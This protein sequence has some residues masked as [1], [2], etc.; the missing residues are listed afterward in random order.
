MTEWWFNTRTGEVEEGPQSLWMDR[1]G[2][3]ES[4]ADAARAN[5]IIAERAKQWAKEDDD[6]F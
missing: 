1:L 5:E 2:P 6:D 4:Y 3:F